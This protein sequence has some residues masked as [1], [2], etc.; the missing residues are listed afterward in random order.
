MSSAY[1][2]LFLPEFQQNLGFAF[3]FAVNVCGV[4]ADTFFDYFISSKI[5]NAIE[6][7][8]PKFVCGCS[9]TEL[10]LFIFERVGFDLDENIL[11]Q[12]I[13]RFDRTPEY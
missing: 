1:S 4:E 7:G 13:C 3:D 2:K 10:A 12:D 6:M 9:G 11:K 8:S 5:A